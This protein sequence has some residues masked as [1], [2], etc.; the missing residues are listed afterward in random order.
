MCSLL[1]KQ[2]CI[3]LVLVECFELIGIAHKHAEIIVACMRSDIKHETIDTGVEL[4]VS[5]SSMLISTI[6]I[7]CIANG[8]ICP[9]VLESLNLGVAKAKLHHG[10]TTI[11]LV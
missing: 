2:A 8:S 1:Q 7:P 10:E 4:D 9:L 11:L 3:R 5:I 6:G